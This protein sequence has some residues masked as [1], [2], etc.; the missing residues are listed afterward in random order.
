MFLTCP[1]RSKETWGVTDSLPM[2]LGFKWD[3]NCFFW[4]VK[5]LWNWCSAACFST[6]REQRTQVSW[7]W[8]AE[9]SMRFPVDGSRR[10]KEIFMDIQWPVPSLSESRANRPSDDEIWGLLRPP[11]RDFFERSKFL[12]IGVPRSVF[13]LNESRANRPVGDDS[14]RFQWDFQLMVHGNS[15]KFLWI[16]NDLFS[17]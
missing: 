6:K 4:R 7:W 5:I 1:T 8:F 2:I 11:F 16:F 10:F 17:H 13:S 3:P 14:R 12:G 9:I 15:K